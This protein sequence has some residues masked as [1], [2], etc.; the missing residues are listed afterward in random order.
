[1]TKKMPADIFPRPR[2]AS[3]FCQAMQNSSRTLRRLS[4]SG[5]S[6]SGPHSQSSRAFGLM[7]QLRT[8]FLAGSSQ[9]LIA[10]CT[11]FGFFWSAST[12]SSSVMPHQGYPIFVG[13]DASLELSMENLLRYPPTEVSHFYN[14][15]IQSKL[16][17]INNYIIHS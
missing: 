14:K 16:Y 7:R 5:D 15:M 11:V 4:S 17:L 13:R 2:K 3:R 10:S 9:R 8:K 12:T 1:M 6:G